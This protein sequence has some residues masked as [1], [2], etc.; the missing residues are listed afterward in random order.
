MTHDEEIL[1]L[2]IWAD[3][4]K[5][6]EFILELINESFSGN[7]INYEYGFV[8]TLVVDINS[9]KI[10]FIV[11][12]YYKSWENVKL[13]RFIPEK[14]SELLEFGKPDGIIY[15]PKDDKIIFAYEETSATPTGNQPLQR[16]ERVWYSAYKK[17]PF[18]YLIG[19]HGLHDDGGI[20]TLP[21][22]VPYL[23]LKLSAQYEIPSLA[24]LY[25]SKTEPENYSVGGAKKKW[26]K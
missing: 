26:K 20:R 19:K 7:G 1:E 11:Y 23:G 5:E 2:E 14:I 18:V 9:K 24:L 10:K 22:W 12:G 25:G 15:D 3:S 4:F 13:K 16:A 6:G 8:P 17:I 21:I